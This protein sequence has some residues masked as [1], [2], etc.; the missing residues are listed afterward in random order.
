MVRH[1]GQEVV[2]SQE[3]V[4]RSIPRESVRTPR[5]VP[6]EEAWKLQEQRRFEERQK[7]EETQRA[8]LEEEKKKEQMMNK[9]K[10]PS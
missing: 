8:K 10:L 6:W 3:T 1:N 9:V 4:Q 7:Q 2:A 5:V